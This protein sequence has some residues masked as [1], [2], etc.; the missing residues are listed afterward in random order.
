AQMGKL[1]GDKKYYDDAVKQITQFSA[2]MFNKDAGLYMHG[3]IAGME[4]HPEFRWARANG[5]ALLAMTELLDV[6]PQD[7]PG[8][9]AVLEL[10]RAPFPALA[11]LPPPHAT[12]HQ[13]LA[14]NDPSLQTSATSLYT[15]RIP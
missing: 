5:W 2:R 8:R 10:F 14:P 13:L 4:V 1:T 3:W 7:H 11:A 15:Q 6:L 9:P 12:W